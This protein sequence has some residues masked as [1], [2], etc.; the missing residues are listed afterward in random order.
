M[1]VVVGAAAAAAVVL[2]L[3]VVVLSIIQSTNATVSILKNQSGQLVPRNPCLRPHLEPK[4]FFPC[5]V[6]L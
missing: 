3:V 4:S 2:V 1:V 6:P 5:W